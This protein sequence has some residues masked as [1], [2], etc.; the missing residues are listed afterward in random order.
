MLTFAAV[1]A[2]PPDFANCRVGGGSDGGIQQ[3][4]EPNDQGHNGVD[5][6]RDGGG[7]VAGRVALVAGTAADVDQRGVA[8]LV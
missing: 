1:P 5:G 3:A 7:R 6:Q 2:G 4:T 8:G